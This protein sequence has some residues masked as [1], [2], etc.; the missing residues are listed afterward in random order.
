MTSGVYLLFS[1]GIL[2]G[3]LSSILL[4]KAHAPRVL[5]Y[6]IAGLIIGQSGFKIV[7]IADIDNLE[8]FNI[9]ALAIIGFLVGAEIRISDMR[10]YGKQF[11]LILFGEGLGAFVLVSFFTGI[12]VGDVDEEES[13]EKVTKPMTLPIMAP[14]RV[15]LI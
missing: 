10:R 4:K 2:G 9:F 8:M 11:S 6:I 13:N 14:I 15:H 1:I 7:T 12:S 3:I 5:G